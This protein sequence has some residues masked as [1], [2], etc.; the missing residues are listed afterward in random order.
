MTP[1]QIEKD[2][3]EVTKVYKDKSRSELIETLVITVRGLEKH[4]QINAASMNILDRLWLFN[5]HLMKLLEA[6]GIELPTEPTEEFIALAKSKLAVNMTWEHESRQFAVESD[7][8][9]RG[10]KAIE[11]RHDQEGGSRDLKAKIRAIYATGKYL[12]KDLCAEEEYQALGIKKLGTARGYLTGEPDPNP[13]PA[14]EQAL[15]AKQQAKG[16]K[17]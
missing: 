2:I 13:W 11:A 17:K 15:L 7:R 10:K 12:T 4:K 5:N 1:E 14:K 8:K 16:K 6:N 9:G 3:A